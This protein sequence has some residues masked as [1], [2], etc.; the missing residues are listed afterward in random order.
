MIQ[1]NSHRSSV[2]IAFNPWELYT[3]GLKKAAYFNKKY[4]G[5]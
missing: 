5:N 1:T 4:I 3:Q 2:F